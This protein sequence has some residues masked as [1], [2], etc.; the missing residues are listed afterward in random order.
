MLLDA[1]KNASGVLI[2]LIFERGR[3]ADT[4]IL[5]DDLVEVQR[6]LRDD[7]PDVVLIVWSFVGNSAGRWGTFREIEAAREIRAQPEGATVPLILVTARDDQKTVAEAA[8]AGANLLVPAPVLHFDLIGIVD[9][10]IAGAPVD[11]K[12]R[13]RRS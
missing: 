11:L 3:P 6:L 13:G 10:V 8:E 9:D 4:V 2:K 1:R 7:P 5:L 12:A